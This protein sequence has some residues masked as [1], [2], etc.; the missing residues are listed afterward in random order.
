MGLALEILPQ[1]GLVNFEVTREQ[2]ADIEA[3]G[4]TAARNL[5]ALGCSVPSIEPRKGI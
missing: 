5:K 1:V 3:K 2:A 4:L